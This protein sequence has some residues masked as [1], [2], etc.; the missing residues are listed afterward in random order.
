MK[1]FLFLTVSTDGVE[2]SEV[3]ADIKDSDFVEKSEVTTEDSTAP[4][5]GDAE[6]MTDAG[7]S[8]GEHILHNFVKHWPK[9]IPHF[10]HSSPWIF[11]A[12]STGEE[13]T[14]EETT[15][16]DDTKSAVQAEMS[17]GKISCRKFTSFFQSGLSQSCRITFGIWLGA[18]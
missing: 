8:E 13:T 17:D 10:G 9:F 6:S 11:I 14:G 7:M 16:K 3:S 1:C 12:G 5:E 2:K 4:G 18:I 15:D